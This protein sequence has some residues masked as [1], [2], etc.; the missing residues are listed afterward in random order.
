MKRK[1]SSTHRQPA[2][3]AEEEL[4]ELLADPTLRP[5]ISFLRIR[6]AQPAADPEAEEEVSVPD[7][8]LRP[9]PIV[10]SRVESVPG[11]ECEPDESVAG[12]DFNQPQSV[13]ATD[14]SPVLIEQ[15]S[16]HS[17]HYK[18]SAP[19]QI[20]VSA[21]SVRRFHPRRAVTLPEGHSHI[22]Q[23][24]YEM[25]WSNG[26]PQVREFRVITLGFGTMARLAHLSL[27][28]CRLNIRSLVHKLAVEEVEG[29]RCDEQIGTTY[30]IY[31]PAAVMRR[32]KAAGFEWVVR[33]RGVAFVDPATGQYLTP[34]VTPHAV[35][36]AAVGQELRTERFD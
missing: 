24:L 6:E 21:A 7:A 12:T 15:L 16:I 18:R 31:S 5:S 32:R 28:N 4:A 2:L 30:R 14:S 26:T 11:A 22:E 29:P 9:A 34:P 17:E 3:S 25:L 8:D 20:A 33:T 27:N 19:F 10:F 23:H 13:P 35:R 36:R 1:L